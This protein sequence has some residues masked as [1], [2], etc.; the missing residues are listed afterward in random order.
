MWSFMWIQ[1][2]KKVT[3]GLILLLIL[4]VLGGLLLPPLFHKKVQEKSAEVFMSQVMSQEPGQ[5]RVLSIEDNREA[6][7]WRLRAMDLAE[8][9]IIL[10]TFDMSSGNSGKD[11]F[12]SLLAAAERGVKVRILVDGLNGLLKL[13][14]DVYWNVLLAGVMSVV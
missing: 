5:E 9:E 7:I 11:I 8:E 12:S 4:Y 13:Q 1:T 6:L 14:N 2:G 3:K 10:A